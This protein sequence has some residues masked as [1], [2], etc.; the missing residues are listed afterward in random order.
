MFKPTGFFPLGGIADR[1]MITGEFYYNHAGYDTNIFND[2][3]AALLMQTISAAGVDPRL[4][5]I[6]E[7]NSYS[8]YYAMFAASISRF[9][10]EPM[11]FSCSALGNFSQKCFVLSS[12]L[13]YQSLHDFTAG[14][15]I[16][17]Y[18]G[19]RHTE[20][21]FGNQGIEVRLQAG[22]VF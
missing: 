6:Y 3:R 11:S 5:R 9:I 21:T 2:P 17:G 4:L 1:L 20:Y 15:M 13:T 14:I 7:P 16:N 22:I 18:A 19:P 12:G 10:I 8:K